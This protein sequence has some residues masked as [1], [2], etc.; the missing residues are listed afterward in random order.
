MMKKQKG[1]LLAV[2]IAAIMLAMA[3][4]QSFAA[5]TAKGA[6]S[7]EG[8]YVSEVY[9][10]YGKDEAAAKKVL[11]DKGFTPVPGNLN[12]GAGTYVMMG[13]KKTSDQSEAI[14]DMAVMNSK[15]E[16]SVGDY[17]NLL[18]KKKEE[19]S[20][21]LKEFMIVIKE[22]RAN[23]KAGDGN[24]KIAHDLLNNYIE[25]DSKMKMGDLLL[26]DTVQDKNDIEDT[27]K[28]DN[29]GKTPD[30]VTIVMQGNAVALKSIYA[31]LGMAVDTE[32]TNLVDRFAKTDYDKM[33]EEQR[34]KNPGK[35][36]ARIV[37]GLKGMYDSTAK[38]LALAAKDLRKTLKEY[39]DSKLQ[40]EDASP[41]DMDKEFGE[42]KTVEKPEDMVKVVEKTDWIATGVIYE[43]LKNYEGGRF[44]KGD[45]LKFFMEE[46]DEKNPE[47]FYPLAKAITKG[48]KAALSVVPLQTLLRYAMTENSTWAEQAKATKKSTEDIM[49]VSVYE[50]VDRDMFLTDGTVAL[51]DEAK[52]NKAGAVQ[53]DENDPAIWKIFNTAALTAYGAT[54]ASLAGA[55]AMSKYFSKAKE[56]FEETVQ[57][58]Y[59]IVSDSSTDINNNW[60]KWAAE[61]NYDVDT[62]LKRY[63]S[64]TEA[65]DEMTS[66]AMG[67]F[68]KNR[69]EFMSLAK[70]FDTKRYL[71]AGFKY[72]TIALGLISAGITIYNL[73]KTEDVE[74]PPVPKYMVDS[75]EGK[76]GK[77]IAVYYK[78]AAG[79]GM[80]YLKDKKNKGEAADTKAYEGQQWLVLY[81]TKDEK[82]GKPITTD[83]AVQ[84]DKEIP[85]GYDGTLHKIG[86][87]GAVNMVAVSYMN[88]SKA[89]ALKN[90]NKKVFLFYKRDSES[91]T[92]STFSGGTI[93]IVA[94]GGIAL[95][96]LLAAM[97]MR[98]RRKSSMA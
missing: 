84:T 38:G 68:Q 65:F 47:R 13:Y 77:Q 81:T 54:A 42:T 92:A 88:F 67:G 10:A 9:T 20:D 90:K 31:I 11:E 49:D 30:L 4:M 8:K 29:P 32:K 78:T 62:L 24:A 93:A 85:S 74:L 34:Q 69:D 21:F 15:G 2:L 80:D 39:E 51:T 73:V 83:F 6:D 95:G 86:E 3:P 46:P 33:L 89:K 87:K 94:F 36:E 55:I 61:K 16:F 45:L 27:V 19:I 98:T 23:Y 26:A 35:S 40:L 44:K 53:V 58:Y 52:R 43:C 17:E 82:A 56:A 7:S 59:S 18:K 63:D 22:Y 57:R 97:V 70:S 71:S 64:M 75:S 91:Q 5:S 72:L 41:K 48:Q 96:A 76:D 12:E 60:Y 66:Q 37:Q 28:A 79:N 25:D 1:K 50:G 14:R